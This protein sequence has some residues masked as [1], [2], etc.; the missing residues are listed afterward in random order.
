MF[1]TKLTLSAVAAILAFTGSVQA[2]AVTE[3]PAFGEIRTGVQ[4]AAAIAKRDVDLSYS[5]TACT[6][7]GLTGTCEDF[8]LSLTTSSSSTAC[9]NF[10]GALAGSVISVLFNGGTAPITFY[11]DTDCSTQS[12]FV[13]FEGVPPS[14]QGPP[15]GSSVANLNTAEFGPQPPFHS[16]GV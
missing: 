16:F 12:G 7:V 15:S 10:D 3:H 9:V 13:E 1:T 5:I 14:F 8:A 6:G 2:A 4:K 11:S